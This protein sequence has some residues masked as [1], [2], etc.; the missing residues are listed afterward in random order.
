VLDSR[1]PEGTRS[2]EIE[3]IAKESGKKLIYILNKIDL[4]S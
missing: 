2:L 1:D 4:I 3:E